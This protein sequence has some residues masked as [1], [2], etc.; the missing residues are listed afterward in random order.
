MTERHLFLQ[1]RCLLPSEV[2][3][4]VEEFRREGQAGL[5]PLVVQQLIGMGFSKDVADWAA[6]SVEGATVEDKVNAALSML[7]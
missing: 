7:S 5:L 4:L 2:T 3:D 1:P 6:R